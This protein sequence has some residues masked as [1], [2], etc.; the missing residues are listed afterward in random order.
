MNLSRDFARQHDEEITNAVAEVL[1][2]GTL[3]PRD[4]LLMQRDTHN[5]KLS[6]FLPEY[7]KD[8]TN[9]DYIWPYDAIQRELDH[10]L[11]KALDD[12]RDLIRVGNQQDKATLLST[13]TSIFAL[14]SRFG[15]LRIPIEHLIYLAK[16]LF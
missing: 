15:L 12:L 1:D 5:Q 16:Q 11:A 3:N 4:K 14:I 10:I 9:E 13:D 6:N 2:L 8:V 7:I